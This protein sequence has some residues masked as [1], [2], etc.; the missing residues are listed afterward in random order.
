MC[1]GLGGGT[2]ER[3]SAD[4]SLRPPLRSP[5]LRSPPVRLEK[6]REGLLSPETEPSVEPLEPGPPVPCASVGVVRGWVCRPP[7]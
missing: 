1:P 2:Q 6:Y 5:R 7:P 3:G 4:C